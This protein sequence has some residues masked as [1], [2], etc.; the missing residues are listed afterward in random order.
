MAMQG[1]GGGCLSWRKRGLIGAGMAVLWS[2]EG[3]CSIRVLYITLS[4]HHQDAILF[5]VPHVVSVNIRAWQRVAAWWC[6]HEAPVVLLLFIAKLCLTCVQACPICCLSPLSQ[7]H[8]HASM[9]P[10]STS[11]FQLHYPSMLT[12]CVLLP[13]AVLCPAPVVTRSSPV[14]GEWR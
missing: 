7:S 9:S 6:I 12:A 14:P 10:A 1:K 2:D 4:M 13:L 5:H 3:W 8:Q 11:I